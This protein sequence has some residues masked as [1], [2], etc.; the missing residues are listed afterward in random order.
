MRISQ[1]TLIHPAPSQD[2]WNRY[3][4]HYQKPTGPPSHASS[5]RINLRLTPLVSGAPPARFELPTKRHRRVRCG[6]KV[7]LLTAHV[8]AFAGSRLRLTLDLLKGR[9]NFV[10]KSGRR[11]N[12]TPPF[13]GLENP[14]VCRI[15][16]S[17]HDV[18]DSS[19][20]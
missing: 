16:V 8:H 9:R 19:V 6:S 1:A 13:L 10:R 17:L 18:W 3:R 15:M 7:K 2:E 4:A 5:H 14:I 11:E 20:C 12:R